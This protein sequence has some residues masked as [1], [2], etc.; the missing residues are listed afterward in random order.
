MMSRGISVQV[1]YRLLLNGFLVNTDS[2]DISKISDFI[3]E[4]EKI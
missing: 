3:N 2:I 4:I 1:A